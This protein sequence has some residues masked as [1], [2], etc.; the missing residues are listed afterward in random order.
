MS[1]SVVLVLIVSSEI[2]DTE[3]ICSSRRLLLTRGKVLILRQLKK[4]RITFQLNE[5]EG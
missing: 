5:A 4:G 1:A 3:D 2:G